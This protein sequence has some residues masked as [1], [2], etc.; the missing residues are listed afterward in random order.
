VA[1]LQLIDGRRS[2]GAIIDDLARTYAAP[3]AEIA[4]DVT[5]MLEDLVGRGAIAL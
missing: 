5:A 1:V 2:V 3:R 4:G